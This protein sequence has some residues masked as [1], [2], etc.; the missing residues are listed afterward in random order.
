MHLLRTLML[1]AKGSSHSLLLHRN[2][3]LFQLSV[4]GGKGDD[5]PG[6]GVDNILLSVMVRGAGRTWN[7][8]SK[9]R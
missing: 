8:W 1:G 3:G 4:H 2:L 9:S 7:C 6:T 5:F